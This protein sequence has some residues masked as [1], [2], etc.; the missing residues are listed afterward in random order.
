VPALCLPGRTWPVAV[1]CRQ[2][3]RIAG[4]E[5]CLFVTAPD[6]VGDYKETTSRF[7]QWRDRMVDCGQPIA[8]VGQDDQ[9]KKP[10]PWALFDALFIGGSTAWK[11]GDGAAELCREAKAQGKYL[12]MGRVNTQQRIRY[13]QSLGCDSIDGT[14]FSM[15][16]KTYLPHALRMNQSGRQ[17][18]L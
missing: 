5:G 2:L 1:G 8:F 6:V 12:H 11:M 4:W 7:F 13:A 18:A 9:E 15:Y 14:A 16:R 10:V 17:L 3:E